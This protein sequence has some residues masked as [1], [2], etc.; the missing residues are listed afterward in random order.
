MQSNYRRLG[1]YIRSVNVRNSDDSIKELLGINIDKFFMPSVANV[2]GTDLSKYKV[3]KRNQFACNRMHVG[4]DHRIPVALSNKQHQFIVSPAYDV[5]EI[6]DES[7]LLPEFLMLWFKRKEFDRNAWFY[8]D[9]DVRG[10]LSWDAFTGIQF[11]LLSIEKQKELVA[12]YQTVE[13][14]IQLNNQ[15]CEKLEETAQTIYRH[16][17]EDFEFPV[18]RHCEE[19][20]TSDEAISMV[21]EPQSTYPGTERSRSYKSS[22]GAMV[23]NEELGK[24]IPEGWKVGKLGEYIQSYSKSHDFKKSQLIFFNTSDILDG[25]FLHCNYS[26]VDEMPGQAKKSIQKN[27]IL[28]SEIRPNNRRFA[29]V[30]NEADD[31]VVSTKLMVLRRINNYLGLHRLY[32][33]LIN[34]ATIKDLQDSANGRSGTFPQITFDED[35][36]DRKIVVAEKQIENIYDNI[37][38]AI[39]NS[40]YARKDQNKKLEEL[41]SLLLGKMAVEN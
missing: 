7:I 40:V 27:D 9:A 20:G 25:E 4:R 36:R 38:K 23:Y 24:E 3:V 6:I 2:V 13:Q 33:Y 1:D 16:W 35:L 37:L 41:K 28:Y 17:F 22:G 30:R 15:L 12:E 32:Y 14:R 11:P 31:Y 19:R 5:F 10:G 26:N 29:L 39:Y 18:Q 8:T 21:A 34:D